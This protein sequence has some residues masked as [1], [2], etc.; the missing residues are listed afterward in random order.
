[1][2]RFDDGKEAMRVSIFGLGY[3]GTVTAGH[4]AAAGHDVIGV[5]INQTKIDLINS[6]HSPVYE[7]GM[8]KLI[9]DA[10]SSGRLEAT[11]DARAALIESDI[12]FITVGT[13]SD[14]D[15][16][17]DT[18][19]LRRVCNKLGQVFNNK[20]DFHTFVVRSTVL[21]G[22]TE[23]LI[24]P[25]IEENSGKKVF[26]DFDICVNPHFL[27][28]GSLV[29]DFRNPPFT[30]I[31][32]EADGAGDRVTRL[33][34]EVKSTVLRTS[35]RTAEM[36]KYASDA[37]HGLKV[38][39]ANEI[40]AVCKKFGI[41]SHEVMSIFRADEKLN[42]SG[43]YLEPGFAFGGPTV[44]GNIQTL[45]R[46]S[47]L[48]DTELPA[49]SSA[50]RSNEASIGRALDMVLST[51]KKKI[52]MIGLAFK[53]G[54]DDLRESP[55]VKL[56]AG[57]IAEGCKVLVYDKAVSPTRL[58]DLNRDYIE[59]KIPDFESILVGSFEEVYKWSEVI[60]VGHPDED[61]EYLAGLD[62]DRIIID[63]ARIAKDISECSGNYHGISW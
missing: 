44:V 32:Q 37:F 34:S 5:D 56:A 24:V 21:P 55:L 33:Y 8:D 53:P 6:E 3:V 18:T 19:Y 40:G 46:S 61:L 62:T 26:I 58:I 22:M 7:R 15:G 27:R 35:I 60:V 25:L 41:D 50:L 16:Q 17:I 29:E 49:L 47:G 28:I 10:V 43:S 9:S 36:I 48:A 31:G 39:F 13:P 57:L 42:I 11:F 23:E 14:S 12:S 4:F 45:L 2:E 59:S 1:V 30:L 63:L 20:N 52:G 51:G 54:T 38:S